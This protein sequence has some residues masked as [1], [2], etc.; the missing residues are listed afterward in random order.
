MYKQMN[1]VMS[2]YP[3][4][5]SAADR[6]DKCKCPNFDLCIFCFTKCCHKI[7]SGYIWG[8]LQLHRNV[9]SQLNFKLA[10]KWK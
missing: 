4:T 2:K 5:L 8:F 1:Q 3:G 7:Y 9:L 10:K 6:L